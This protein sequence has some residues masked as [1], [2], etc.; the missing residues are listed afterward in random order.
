MRTSNMV[1]C[2]GNGLCWEASDPS[3]VRPLAHYDRWKLVEP[4]FMAVCRRSRILSRDE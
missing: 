3:N 2:W 1:G 4:S